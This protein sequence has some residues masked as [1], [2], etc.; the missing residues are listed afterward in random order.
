MYFMK[1]CIYASIP[2]FGNYSS[3]GL[4]KNGT[5]ILGQNYVD[6]GRV[7]YGT[8]EG[9]ISFA[10]NDILSLS[11]GGTTWTGDTLGFGVGTYILLLKI[12]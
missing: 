2:R 5:L 1:T 8:L 10:E 4:L 12:S 11:F 9:K 7:N 6:A 3:L